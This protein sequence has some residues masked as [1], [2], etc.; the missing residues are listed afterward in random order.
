ME[1]ITS[2]LDTTPSADQY[3]NLFTRRGHVHPSTTGQTSL[4]D[5]IEGPEPASALDIER[6]VFL[7]HEA[8]HTF[9]MSDDYSVVKRGAV[10]RAILATRVK[11]SLSAKDRKTVRSI[12]EKRY[13]HYKDSVYSYSLDIILNDSLTEV[14]I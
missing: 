9:E 3:G 10:D 1:Y 12:L 13:P 11:N 6:W 2:K 5:N 4:F 8:D 7:I 14:S